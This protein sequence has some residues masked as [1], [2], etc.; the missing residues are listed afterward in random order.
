MWAN[1]LPGE[2]YRDRLAQME[3]GLPSPL[4]TEGW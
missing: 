4:R 2:A 1:D 3:A